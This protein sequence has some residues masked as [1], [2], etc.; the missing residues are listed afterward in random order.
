MKDY[1]KQHDQIVRLMKELEM[2][3]PDVVAGYDKMHRSHATNGAL[4]AKVKELMAL[5][6][7]LVTHCEGCIVLHVKHALSA[8]ATRREILETISVAIMMGGGPVL[9]QA[10]DALAALDHFTEEVKPARL[11]D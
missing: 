3:L 6:I 7:S 10:C 8:G 4:K 1:S 5:S 2:E 11:Y 9:V